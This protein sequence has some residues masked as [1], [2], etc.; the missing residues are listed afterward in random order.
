MKILVIDNVNYFDYPTGGIMSFYRSLLPA[1]GDNLFLV[2]ITTDNLTPVGKW[3]HRVIFGITFNYYSM[4]NIKPNPKK[5]L[6]PERIKNCYFIKK[7]IYKIFENDN[8]DIILT[9]SPEV[10]YF[11]PTNKLSK[12]CFLMPGVNNPML[13]SRYQWAR[14]LGKIYDKFFLMP[15]LSKVRWILA[16]ADHNAIEEFAKR[17]EGKI[18]AENIIQFPTRYNDNYYYVDN[19]AKCRNNLGYSPST[20][21]YV[22]V[23]RLGWFKG[24]KLMIDAFQIVNQQISDSKLIFIGDGE[25]EL[26][27]QKYIEELNLSNSIELVGKKMPVDIS[28]YLN[29]SNVFVMGSYTEGWST[30]LVEACACGVPCV[31]TDF[32]SAEE[33]INNGKNGYVVNNRDKKQFAKRMID[34]LSIPREDVILFNEKFNH[35]SIC[36]LKE[37]FQNALSFNS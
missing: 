4:A 25:D 20:S 28:M 11:I 29:A 34:V 15:K 24:W 8:S 33:M 22:T 2:G 1:F 3:T 32:S 37:D 30:T 31:V 26:K 27:I 18:N 35:L 9:Q 12:T 16:A 14:H 19:R 17:S 23:G 7:N 6:I 21:I 36:H 10:V 13:I 5:P